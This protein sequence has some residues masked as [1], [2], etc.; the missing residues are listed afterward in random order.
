L[1]A[2]AARVWR[3]DQQRARDVAGP[4][5]ERRLSCGLAADPGPA[6]AD[7]LF[8]RGARLWPAHGRAP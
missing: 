3:T 6:P 2:T 8:A 4:A 7:R 1:A 5:Q